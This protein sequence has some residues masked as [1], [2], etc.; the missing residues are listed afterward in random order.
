MFF[1]A[2]AITGVAHVLG[3]LTAED[4]RVLNTALNI[5]GAIGVVWIGY[6]QTKLLAREREGLLAQNRRITDREN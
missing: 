2:L 3:I 5:I 1:I 6:L 4:S